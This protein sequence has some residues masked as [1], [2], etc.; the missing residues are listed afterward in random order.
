MDQIAFK[1]GVNIG[2]R[3]LEGLY[4]DG[5]GSP[6]YRIVSLIHGG[7]YMVRPTEEWALMR[8]LEK[9]SISESDFESESPYATS[10][11]SHYRP[12]LGFI[13][14]RANTKT[15]PNRNTKKMADSNAKP[16][17]FPAYQYIEYAR[18]QNQT[19]QELY[20]EWF[21]EDEQKKNIGERD[22]TS[23]DKRDI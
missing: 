20:D 22:C 17:P 18:E 11:S 5:T 13:P 21:E 7:V 6:V 10:K 1:I 19:L 15:Y 4:E 8:T 3:G 14:S 9:Y 16:E 23:G 2:K 12:P